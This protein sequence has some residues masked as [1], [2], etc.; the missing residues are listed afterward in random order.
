GVCSAARI[1]TKPWL[2]TSIRYVCPTWRLSD[3]E[4]NCVST[5][6]R[7]TSA[8]RQLL[9]AT[10]T[11]RYLPPIGTAG[12]E[13]CCVSGNSRL[14]WPP[15]RIIARTSVLT[16]TAL[17]LQLRTWKSQLNTHDNGGLTR[18]VPHGLCRM[19][20]HRR[21]VARGGPVGRGTW[22]SAGGTH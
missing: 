1:S 10:S 14:P 16:A 15:P 2:K 8:C 5:K 4:L 11:S 17:N 19:E 20:S 21:S 9:I 6:I 7:R 12:L 13:R 22:R 18:G 3:A